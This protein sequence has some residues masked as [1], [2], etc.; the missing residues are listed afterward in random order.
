VVE[1]HSSLRFAWDWKNRTG[2]DFSTKLVKLFSLLV[3]YNIVWWIPII[4]GFTKVISYQAGFVSFA[5]VTYFRLMANLIRNNLLS[6]EQAVKF[7]FQIP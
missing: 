3:V 6:L 7:P 5:V 1:Y 4:L 2:K